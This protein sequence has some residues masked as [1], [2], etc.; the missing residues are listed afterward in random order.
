[1]SHENEARSELD[2]EIAAFQRY[3]HGGFRFGEG[4]IAQQEVQRRRAKIAELRGRMQHKM[5]GEASP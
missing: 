1:M 2:A 5:I 3:K 4:K